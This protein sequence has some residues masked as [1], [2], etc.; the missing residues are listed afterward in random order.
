M[1]WS[2]RLS[3]GDLSISGPGGYGTVTGTNKLIQDLRNWILEPRGSD[4]SS[5][6]YGSTID[7]GALPDGSWVEPAIGGLA[8]PEQL[9]TIEA[10]IRRI[11]AA[12]Q[13]QQADRINQEVI[14]YAGKNTY[15]SGEILS[16]INDVQATQILTTLFV[17]VSITTADGDNLTFT[18]P[19]S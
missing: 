1:T 14:L 4:P 18:Q 11:L 15:G 3:S 2:L 16:A 10:E 7:G 9:M 17:T 13:Q 12:Y 5:P 6:D 8:T 19:L